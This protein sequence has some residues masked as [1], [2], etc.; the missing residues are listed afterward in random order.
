MRLTGRMAVPVI[1]VD[2]QVVTGFD[3]ARLH[4]LLANP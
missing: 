1:V 3:K 2:R 4:V